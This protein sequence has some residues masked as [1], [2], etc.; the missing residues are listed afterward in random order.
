[1][2]LVVRAHTRESMLSALNEATRVR[3]VGELS[4]LGLPSTTLITEL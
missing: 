3:E 4:G 2:V 1:M